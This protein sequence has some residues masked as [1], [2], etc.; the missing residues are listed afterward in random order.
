MPRKKVRTK[1]KAREF[2]DRRRLGIDRKIRALITGESN[3]FGIDLNVTVIYEYAN[4]V[5]FFRSH[6]DE[7]NARWFTSLDDLVCTVKI[8]STAINKLKKAASNSNTN[9]SMGHIDQATLELMKWQEN[10][11]T[12]GTV[13][14]PLPVVNR[15]SER[16]ESILGSTHPSLLGQDGGGDGFSQNDTDGD[17]DS[18]DDSQDEDSDSSD[19]EEDYEYTMSPKGQ[20]RPHRQIPLITT[21]R[22]NRHPPKRRREHDDNQR[23]AQFQAPATIYPTQNTYAANSGQLQLPIPQLQLSGPNTSMGGY[24]IPNGGSSLPMIPGNQTGM[25]VGMAD[26]FGGYDI[27]NGPGFHT[28]A[29]QDITPTRIQRVP[30]LPKAKKIRNNKMSRSKISTRN[31]R[32]EG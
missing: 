11:K 1:D 25:N 7:S 29:L 14:Q 30:D 3:T 19:A 17:N 32:S 10:Q 22:E 2:F 27:Y 6:L 9:T 23:H 21:P 5:S 8:L 15:R 16:I 28:G 12:S 20:S 18:E 26:P 13:I 24:S 31:E 4:E